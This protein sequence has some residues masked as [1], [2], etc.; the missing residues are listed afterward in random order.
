MTT[1]T[2]HNIYA[3]ERPGMLPPVGP[4][5]TERKQDLAPASNTR[6][7]S[8]ILSL[9]Q[10]AVL[11]LVKFSV[12]ILVLSHLLACGLHLGVRHK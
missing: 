12:G 4:T 5:G 3:P 1:A 10:Y 2:Y 11:R 7:N 9:P 6:V 8:T